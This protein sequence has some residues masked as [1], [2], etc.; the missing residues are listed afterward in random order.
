MARKAR[1][2][3][4]EEARQMIRAG[5]RKADEMGKKMN[6]AVVDARAKVIAFERQ[7]TA[8][9]GSI[10][11]AMNRASASRIVEVESRAPGNPSPGVEDSVRIRVPNRG[12]VIA[13]GGGARLERGD[14]IVG[15]V[16]V[17]GG[18]GEE[19]QAVAEAVAEAFMEAAE[20]KAA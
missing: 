10:D 4:L 20:R 1:D 6:I 3:S 12:K 9:I 5:E 18:V 14:E 15:A 19:A 17:S 16:G 7:D 8:W 2:I 11:I 13:F